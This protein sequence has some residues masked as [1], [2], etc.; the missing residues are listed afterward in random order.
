[1]DVILTSATDLLKPKN[2]RADALESFDSKPSF[3]CWDAT[4]NT[5]PVDGARCRTVT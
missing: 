3:C 5:A 1:M 2:L 4:D